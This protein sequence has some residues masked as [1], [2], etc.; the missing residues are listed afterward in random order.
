MTC[1]RVGLPSLSDLTVE[2][3]RAGGERRCRRRPSVSDLA[4]GEERWRRIPSVRDLTG[5]EE[6][7]S[8]REGE[9]RQL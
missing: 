1:T 2:E 7:E 8:P 4:G 6:T 5:G 9:C 3:A